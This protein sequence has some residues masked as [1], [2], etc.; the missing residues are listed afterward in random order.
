MLIVLDDYWLVKDLS[1]ALGSYDS[2]LH[3]IP[4]RR[5]LFRDYRLKSLVVDL[6][7][8][9]TSIMHELLSVAHT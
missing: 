5:L 8:G 9:P 6:I 2:I 4:N 1:L 7:E 3:P